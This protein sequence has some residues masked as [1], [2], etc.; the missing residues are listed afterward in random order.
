MKGNVNSGAALNESGCSKSNATLFTSTARLDIDVPGVK[1]LGVHFLVG[2]DYRGTKNKS[3]SLPYMLGKYNASTGEVTEIVNSVQ[4]RS[5]LRESYSNVQK[6]ALQPSIDYSNTFGKNFIN[7]QFVFDQLTTNSSSFAAGKMNYELTDIPELSLGSDSEIVPNSVTGTSSKFA[8][9]SFVGRINYAF[10]DKYMINAIFRADGSVK[11]RDENRWGYFPG[12]SVAWRMTQEEFMAPTRDVL[13][14]LKIRGS[15]G[16][17]GN[18]RVSDWL[19]LRSIGLLKN[20][21]VWEN[22]IIDG[23]QTGSVPAYDLSWEKT[24]TWNA[25]FDA[26]FLNNNL[27]VEFDFYYKYTWDILQSLSASI[28]PSLGGNAPSIHNKGKVDHRCVELTIG[29]QKTFGKDWTF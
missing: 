1:G 19:Y 18:D 3:W 17:T 12:V 25:G 27:T 8:R 13:N 7:A 6:I 14:N 4:G 16:I 23:L 26:G 29:Y 11:F 22:A 10:D 5:V 28:P 21:Y 24:R 9:Q 15:F 20:A 2:F